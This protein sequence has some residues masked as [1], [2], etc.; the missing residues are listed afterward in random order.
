MKERSVEFDSKSS[1][2]FL[3]KTESDPNIC[4]NLNS[5]VFP[6]NR[7]K[8]CFFAFQTKKTKFY[9]SEVF[10]FFFF[11]QKSFFLQ[12]VFCH[13]R[14]NSNSVSDRNFRNGIERYFSKTFLKKFFD[15]DFLKFHS[16]GEPAFE[17]EG[18]G[19]F[20]D[21]AELTNFL[22]GL[23]LTCFTDSLSF[24]LSRSSAFSLSLSQ[25]SP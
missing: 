5:L 2:L 23:R 4:K 14:K 24:S 16:T 12:I 19:H 7:K 11:D 8:K 15:H 22:S 3:L 6:Q 1:P 17:I 13:K 20:P 10:Y 9:G 25:A 18:N 21:S